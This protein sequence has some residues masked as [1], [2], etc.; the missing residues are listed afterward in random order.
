MDIEKSFLSKMITTGSVGESIDLGVTTSLFTEFTKPVYEWAVEFF[1]KH[2]QSPG[3]EALSIDHPDFFIEDTPEPLTFY[4]QALR[5]KFVFNAVAGGL[6]ESATLLGEKKPNEAADSMRKALLEA[7]TTIEDD[8]DIDWCEDPEDRIALYEKRAED[9]GIIGIETPWASLSQ[10]IQGL[11]N[12]HLIMIMAQTKV[13]KSWALTLLALH[14]WLDGHK[15]LLVSREMTVAEFGMRLDAVHFKLPL[16]G[17]RDGKLTSDELERWKKGAKKLKDHERFSIV[18]G[19]RG[20]ASY[21]TAKIR[22]HSPAFVLVDGLYLLEDERGA[23]SDWLRISNISRD[24]KLTCRR[25]NVPIIVTS[26]LNNDDDIARSKA[27]AQD[28][29]VIIKLKQTSEQK[30]SG[31]MELHITHHRHGKTGVITSEWNLDTMS[32][33]EIDS[34]H[35]PSSVPEKTENKRDKISLNLIDNPLDF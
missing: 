15:P 10:V 18:G 7:D 6:R 13:G 12:Q 5:D 23:S 26:Q 3:V 21:I 4:I 1:G 20:G 34:F 19:S 22:K 31:V 32:F 29:D 25:E 24:L 9:G 27:I 14:G 17:I 11:Q 33:K 8:E 16:S 2:K 35:S 30:Q 28:A